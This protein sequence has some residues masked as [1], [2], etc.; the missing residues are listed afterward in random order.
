[1]INKRFHTI[2]YMNG[3]YIRPI[4][5]RHPVFIGSLYLLVRD[6]VANTKVLVIQFSI[7][8]VQDLCRSAGM[9]IFYGEC[10]VVFLCDCF[11]FLAHIYQ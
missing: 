3:Y 10:N 7:R 6:V 11:E 9:H 1:M 8:I 5:I 4:R 2:R